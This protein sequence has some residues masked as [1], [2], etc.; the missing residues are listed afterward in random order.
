MKILMLISSLDIGGAE[1]H[2]C[3]LSA[4]LTELGNEVCVISG[5]GSL[6]Q[7]LSGAGVRHITLPLGSR[8]P[9]K[10]IG[11]YA[12]IRSL[13]RRQHFD[14]IHAHSRIAAYIGERAARRAGICFVTTAHA[15][16]QVTPLKKYMSRWG[17]YVSAVSEDIAEYLREVYRVQRERIEIIPNG[18]DT[19]RFS[20]ERSIREGKSI[21][22]VSRL[23]RDCSAAA[24]SLCSV[25]PTLAKKYSGITVDIVGGG[26]EYP[27]LRELSERVNR[28]IGYACV[29][30]LG[31][32]TDVA[33]IMRERGIFVGVSRAA[34]EAMSSGALVV[35][36]GNEGFFGCVGEG[37]IAEAERSNFCAR[38]YSGITDEKMLSSLVELL[39]MSEEESERRSDFLRKYVSENHGVERCAEL[40][41]HFYRRAIERSC[42]GK[43]DV[44]LCG[45]YGYGNT[46]DDVLLQGAIARARLEYGDGIC[47]LSRHPRRDRYRYGVS[48]VSPKNIFSVMKQI[49]HARCLAFGGGT[50]FQDRT[51]LRSLIYYAVLA[52]IASRRGVRVELWANGLGPIESAVGRRISARILGKCDHLGFRDKRSARLAIALGA[53]REKIALEDD[54]AFRIFGESQ[55]SAK[56]ED[57]GGYAVFAVSGRGERSEILVL[58]SRAE[59]AAKRGLRCIFVGMYPAEDKKISLRMSEAVGGEY[60][61]GLDCGELVELLGGAELVCGMRFHLLVFAKIAGSPFEGV[62][63]DPKIRAFCEENGG[64]YIKG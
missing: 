41:R 13:L 6:A 49:S 43:G 8:A 17:Y 55:S 57:R 22:F 3:S 58:G 11:A 9:T 10:L 32:R 28:E 12:A 21:L 39:D 1:T 59:S 53:D 44:C 20:P 15:R 45:Y 40:T 56:R 51:S 54:L 19:A 14:I 64:E 7:K 25:A 5:G 27:R 26:E 23:D 52:E 29:R 2:L 30:T 62:G 24:Y 18:V 61:D 60:V 31:A 34:L 37:N 63:K 4:A 50:I 42:M 35:L 36:A 48:C 33:P 38:G 16:F 46:G 47:A